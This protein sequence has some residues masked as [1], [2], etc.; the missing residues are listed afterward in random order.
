[1]Q[2]AEK[3]GGDPDDQIPAPANYDELPDWIVRHFSG[4]LLLSPRALRGIKDAVYEEFDLVWKGLA[5]LAREYRDLRLGA[6]E[7]SGELWEAKLVEL[8]LE[9]EN[10]ASDTSR[11][12]YADEYE[13]LDP[14]G[15][16][17]KRSF[18]RDLKKGNSRDARY[19]LRI[20]FYW[21]EEHRQVVVGW[22]PSHLTITS[23]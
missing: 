5:A 14:F 18:E 17:K 11:G 15:S 22:L 8:G 9:C 6:K 13:I 7:D 1:M 23:S 19:C 16:G 4:R 10:A 2:L 12:K 20:Y 21:D 3:L